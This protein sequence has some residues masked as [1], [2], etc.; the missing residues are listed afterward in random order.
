MRVIYGIQFFT[1]LHVHPCTSRLFAGGSWMAMDGG[2]VF[3]ADQT[4]EFHDKLCSLVPRL[5]Q[6]FCARAEVGD[7]TTT[8]LP[9]SK[10][11]SSP[12][13][14]AQSWDTLSNSSRCTTRL[15]DSPD[16]TSNGP[17][18]MKLFLTHL[19]C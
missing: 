8:P 16:W 17:S 15:Y 7:R 2:C 3:W 19:A 1:L 13:D 4:P 9:P 18:Q 10:R 12:F 14:H 11:C 5:F 6:F